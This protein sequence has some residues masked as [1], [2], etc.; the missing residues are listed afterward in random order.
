MLQ[1]YIDQ[2]LFIILYEKEVLK[3]RGERL[4]LF[5]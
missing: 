4:V 2:K 5:F 3:C 1:A